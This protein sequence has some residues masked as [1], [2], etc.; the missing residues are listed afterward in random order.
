MQ[1]LVALDQSLAARRQLSRRWDAVRNTDLLNLMVLAVPELLAAE[2]CG[3]FVLD[4]EADEIWLEAGTA[5]VQRQICV[6]PHHSM[7]GQCV[8]GGEA[9]RLHGLAE[10]E[11]AH[12]QVGEQLGFRVQTALTVP[13]ATEK[14]AVVGALQVLNR[15][16][17][18]PF[19][20]ADQARLEEVAFNL[21][22][23][24]QR[25]YASRDLQHRTQ[26]LDAE[27]QLLQE[28]AAALRP[29][30]S[31]RTFEPVEPAK[32]E[33]FL[34]HRWHGKCYPPFI[35]SRA[36]EHLTQSWDTQANDVLIATHQ[37]VGTHLAKKYLV[38]LI[39]NGANLPA[40]HPMAGG[41]IGHAAV[42]WPE[43]Y[44]SQ[45][46]EA[47][48]QEFLAATSDRPRLWYTHCAN[49]DLP[50]R[51]VHPSTRF[52]AVI[53]DPR[54]VV[55]SQYFF[56]IRHPLLGLNT[57]LDL[58]RFVQ[59]FAEGDLYFG[60]YF[61]H[62]LGWLEPQGVVRSEQVCA[63]RYEDMVEQKLQTVQRLQAFLFPAQDLD[64][65]LARTIAAST[66]FD[67]MKQQISEHPGSF[68]LNPKIY[69]RAGTTDNWR[70][71]LSAAAEATIAA[72]C[73]ERWAGKEADP[74]LGPYLAS[75]PTG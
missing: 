20:A 36:T 62:V 16:D 58:D 59:L 35:N 13:I 15:R 27:I 54:A 40:R 64:P 50:C 17:G 34:H 7:V 55:V 14:G 51:R 22:P 18:Q 10:S 31:Q 37:K 44:L 23:S 38:E 53:R 1:S 33:G 63:L 74:L 21:Q 56:W 11:G 43:V 19:D 68:H 4:P 69:F 49:E 9:I 75:L 61:S 60:D 2:R 67:T 45:E 72:A 29:G 3:L 71:H 47:V 46:N 57:N 30:H 5:V 25:M 28:R 66:D 32:P 24:V 41:D 48:W 73:R 65:E 26:Q 12:R 8:R 39:R 6:D 52:V 42:P 70:Q